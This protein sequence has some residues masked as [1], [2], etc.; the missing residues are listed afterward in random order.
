[1]TTNAC[2]DIHVQLAP[3]DAHLF[4]SE[5]IDYL[6]QEVGHFV[7]HGRRD[8]AVKIRALLRDTA[9]SS[10]DSHRRSVGFAYVAVLQGILEL[11]SDAEDDV[12][13]GVYSDDSVERYAAAAAELVEMVFSAS[14][15]QETGVQAIR[16]RIGDAFREGLPRLRDCVANHQREWDIVFQYV[17][18]DFEK[19]DA[20]V[21]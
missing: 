14:G 18:E 1:M 8:T 17:D 7:K 13:T 3:D 12:A 19:K 9:K 6:C 2:K 4:S 15:M 5:M 10:G 11:L 20:H 16:S 21:A